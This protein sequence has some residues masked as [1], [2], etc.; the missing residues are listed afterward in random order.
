M[1]IESIYGSLQTVV[2]VWA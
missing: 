1:K 2:L